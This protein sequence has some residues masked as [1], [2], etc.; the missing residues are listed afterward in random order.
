MLGFW[1]GRMSQPAWAS[2]LLFQGTPKAEL[3]EPKGPA[4]PYRPKDP[5]QGSLRSMYPK[6]TGLNSPT[7]G[8]PKKTTETEGSSVLRSM[9]RGISELM[10]C[11]ILLLLLLL[12]L[13]LLLLVIIIIYSQQYNNCYSCFVMWSWGPYYTFLTLQEEDR[14]AA[15][16]V[17][18]RLVARK[19]PG[20]F[21]LTINRL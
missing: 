13:L 21:E 16:E 9:V 11:R 5:G 1:V 12:P 6:G 4:L 7:K 8:A 10:L 14:Q 19:T 3:L 18:Q 20:G 17:K 15:E 2:G